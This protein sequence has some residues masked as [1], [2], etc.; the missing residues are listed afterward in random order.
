MKYRKIE[1]EEYGWSGGHDLEQHVPFCLTVGKEENAIS[2]NLTGV[3]IGRFDE[4]MAMPLKA[5]RHDFM[6]DDGHSVETRSVIPFGSEPAV[7]RKFEYFSKIIKVTT[8]VRVKAPVEGNIFSLDEL[9]FSGNWKRFAVI[10]ASGQIRIDDSIKWENMSSSDSVVY[11]SENLFGVILLEAENGVRV[12]IGTGFDVWR[13]NIAEKHDDIEGKL[14]IAVKDG[15]FIIKRHVMCSEIDFIIPKRDWRFNWYMAWDSVEEYISDDA[16]ESSSIS[17]DQFD[18]SDAGSVKEDS[19]IVDAPC[20]HSKAARNRLKKWIRS[21]LNI[22]QGRE[23]LL[24]GVAPH[25][26]S[27]SAHLERAK[28]DKLLHWD[29]PDIIDLWFWANRQLRKKDSCF[30][31][32]PDKRGIF[33]ELPSFKGMRGRMVE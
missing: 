10:R 21:Q 13:W 22:S 26:C 3:T 8:D 2:V 4:S 7:L 30:S 19:V 28:F 14:Q 31:I 1:I 32:I 23:V 5:V 6:E 16:S 27:N 12:E 24:T 33:S 17:L 20:F 9:R 29:L 15:D 18:W 11:E 25:I